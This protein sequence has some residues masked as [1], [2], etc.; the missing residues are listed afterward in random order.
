MIDNGHLTVKI[1]QNIQIFWVNISKKGTRS[2]KTLCKQH[3]KKS[4]PTRYSIK[5]L[6]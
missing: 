2:F 4:F 3:A 1:Y 5:Y 6:D